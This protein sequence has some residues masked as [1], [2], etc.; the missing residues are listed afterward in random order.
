MVQ[1]IVQQKEVHY[2]WQKGGTYYFVR[3]IP[4]DIQEHYSSSRVV[5]CLKT[6]VR[7]KALRLSRSFAQRLE[8]YWLSY[9]IPHQSNTP[10][11]LTYNR[12]IVH[13]HVR[14]PL[15]KVHGILDISCL[16]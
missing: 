3:R 5:I 8:D 14:L 16:H 11:H 1:H 10:L 7:D 9:H 2:F 6:N 4:K 13:D 15:T 12:R